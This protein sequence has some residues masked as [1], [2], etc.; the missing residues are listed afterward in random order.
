MKTS[1]LKQLIKEVLS[2]LNESL[3]FSQRG[4]RDDN[5]DWV[6]SIAKC[7]CG[8]TITFEAPGQDE[9]C[10]KCGAMYN[11]SGQSI[12]AMGYDDDTFD[13]MD[14]EDYWRLKISPWLFIT[15]G[16]TALIMK[17]EKVID[18]ALT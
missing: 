18:T 12:R 2:V 14:A 6:P 11:S 9:E 8:N 4:Y 15:S 13:R 5:G 1:I 17:I 7:H 16:Y 3:E 10:P